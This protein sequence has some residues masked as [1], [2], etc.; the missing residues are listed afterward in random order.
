MSVSAWTLKEAG[1]LRQT[2]RVS[3]LVIVANNDHDNRK[4]WRDRLR[5]IPDSDAYKR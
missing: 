1:H 2:S 4:I 3:A 5:C